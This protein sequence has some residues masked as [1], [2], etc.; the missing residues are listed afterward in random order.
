MNIDKRNEYLARDAVLKTLSDDEVASV[1]M[2]ETA[3]QLADGE[4]YLDL[5]RLELVE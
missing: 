4:D 1:S 5:E 3:A 2:A